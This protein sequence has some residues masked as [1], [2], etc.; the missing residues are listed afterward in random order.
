[1][2]DYG[3]VSPQFWVG[4][5]GKSLRGNVEAQLVALYLMTSPHANMIGVFYC[6]IDYIAKE[7]GLTIEGA[8]KALRSLIEG[9]FCTYEGESEYVFVHRFAAHQLGEALKANDKRVQG[10]INELSKVPKGECRQAF[11]DAYSEHFHLPG[12]PSKPAKRKP[13]RRP[14]EA[15]S[16]PETETE[17]ETEEEI[18]AEALPGSTLPKGFA[19][20]LNDNTEWRIPGD[21]MAEWQSAFPAVDIDQE[22]REMRAWSLANPAHRKTVRGVSAF[23]VRWLQKAQDTPGR[24][25]KAAREAEAFV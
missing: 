7:T 3:K 17:A 9:E 19:I 10:V 23:I 5:T 6:P 14:L 25:K 16:K 8:S 18:S 21:A 1:M 4:K 11:I 12:E 2:R 20:P 13:H 22:L 24:T 15:P